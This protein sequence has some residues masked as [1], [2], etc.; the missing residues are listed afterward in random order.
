VNPGEL[1]NANATA[2]DK[3]LVLVAEDD[4]SASGMLQM[5][6]GRAGYEVRTVEDGHAAMRLLGETPAPDILLLDW[7]LPGITGVEVCRKVRERWDELTLPILMVT[8]RADAHSITEA[9]E[10]GAS[11]YITKPLLGA[12]LRAR[13]AAHLRIK[14]VMAEKRQ[15]H[16]RM[17]ERET[18]STLGLLVSGVAHDLNNPLAGIYGYA[19]LLLEEELEPDIQ[20]AAERIM[21]EVQRCNRIVS[22][23]LS[24]ARSPAPEQALLD[25]R[26][27]LVETVDL[28]QWQLQ[29]NGVRAR[30]LLANDLPIVRADAGQLQRVFLNILINAEHA[31]RE[32]GRQLEIVAEG[33]PGPTGRGDAWLAIRFF[34]DGPPIPAEVLP[35]IFDPLFTTKPAG[36]GTGLGLAICKRILREYGGD[37]EVESRRD[38]TTFTVLLPSAPQARGGGESVSSHRPSVS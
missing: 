16:E 5:L 38:G 29:S 26:D 19:Q 28:R 27:L 9:F 17:L 11:D 36:E 7:M 4:P 25:V 23:L 37:V 21:R 15:L 24:Y 13:V 32:G 35:R 3:P 2:R 1:V 10:A 8:A 34:N 31:L 33:V 18:L 30:L 12:E 14:Q 22:D 20:V 6:L